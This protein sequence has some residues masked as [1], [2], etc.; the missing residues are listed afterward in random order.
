MSGIAGSR[1]HREI[2]IAAWNQGTWSPGKKVMQAGAK[3]ARGR[4]CKM[5]LPGWER[6]TWVGTGKLERTTLHRYEI[7]GHE[8]NKS[9][10]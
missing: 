1:K 5:D 9:T 10:A 6:F 2:E 3:T 4:Q 7:N 8:C